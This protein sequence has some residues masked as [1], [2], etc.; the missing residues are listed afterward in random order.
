MQKEGCKFRHHGMKAGCDVFTPVLGT[1]ET[2]NTP[3]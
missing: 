3:T 1:P 2:S